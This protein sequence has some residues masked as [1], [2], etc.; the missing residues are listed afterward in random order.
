MRFI[1]IGKRAECRVSASGPW[2][3]MEHLFNSTT[4]YLSFSRRLS[5]KERKDL[6]E[7]L[8]ENQ[9][10]ILLKS[11]LL[12]NLLVGPIISNEL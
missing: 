2:K 8:Y 3:P 6:I 9:W 5:Y 12:M 11:Y 4:A 7:I 1:S 10:S